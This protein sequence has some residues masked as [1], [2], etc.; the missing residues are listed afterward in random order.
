LSNYEVQDIPAV[1]AVLEPNNLCGKGIF[2][3]NTHHYMPKS[4]SLGPFHVGNGGK[5]F[6]MPANWTDNVDTAF[7][8]RRDLK[9][10]WL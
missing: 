5:K 8:R 4:F 2:S 6:I 3:V 9:L 7:Q 1:S 10:F